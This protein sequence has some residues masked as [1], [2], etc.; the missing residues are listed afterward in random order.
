M[1]SQLRATKVAPLLWTDLPHSLLGGHARPH[2]APRATSPRQLS[3]LFFTSK[4]PKPARQSAGDR[5]ADVPPTM[6]FWALALHKRGTR[7]TMTRRRDGK[8][9]EGGE[10]EEGS[11]GNEHRGSRHDCIARRYRR[12][13]VPHAPILQCTLLVCPLLFD[14]PFSSLLPLHLACLRPVPSFIPRQLLSF[15]FPAGSHTFPLTPRRDAKH[16]QTDRWIILSATH[17]LLDVNPSR[18]GLNLL[19][20]DRANNNKDHSSP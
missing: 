1:I 2:P 19:C 20:K 18:M 15:F 9:G 5:T 3:R 6:S 10:K 12:F 13:R 14:F 16:R 11:G 8:E 17:A 4:F 7:R